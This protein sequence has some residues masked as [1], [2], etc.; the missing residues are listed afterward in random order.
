MWLLVCKSLWICQF[1]DFLMLSWLYMWLLL[2]IYGMCCKINCGK[3]KYKQYKNVSKWLIC[4]LTEIKIPK[5]NINIKLVWKFE[6][7]LSSS[8]WEILLTYKHMHKHIHKLK[9]KLKWK[10][11]FPGTNKGLSTLAPIL[12]LPDIGFGSP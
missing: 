11:N 9:N 1:G 2:M 6:V 7:N 12:F 8:F 4:W 10:Y 5:F 3:I